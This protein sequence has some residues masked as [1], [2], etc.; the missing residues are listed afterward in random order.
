MAGASDPRVTSPW[1]GQE[2]SCCGFAVSCP[3]P[4]AGKDVCFG[5]R[6]REEDFLPWLF[7]GTWSF[8]KPLLD[9]TKSW[10]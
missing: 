8:G 3:S 10:I 1:P 6:E 5:G 9:C 4:A 7:S 2:D